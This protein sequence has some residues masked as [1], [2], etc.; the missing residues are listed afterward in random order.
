LRF[1][2][3]K[4]V[5]SC[6]CDRYS[7]GACWSDDEVFVTDLVWVDDGVRVDY[8]AQLG[9]QVEEV[10]RHG[11]DLTY[12]LTWWKSWKRCLCVVAE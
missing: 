4:L 9:R 8:F 12:M 6:G 11:V 2:A 5:R 7:A 1:E 10:E 3:R